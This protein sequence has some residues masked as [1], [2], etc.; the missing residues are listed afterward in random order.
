MML[1]VFFLCALL[2]ACSDVPAVPKLAPQDVIV[3]FGDSLT[4]GTGANEEE[5]YPAVLGKLINRRVI[6]AGVAGETTEQG[7]RRL[8]RVLSEHHPRLLILCLGGNDLLR[9]VDE[10]RTAANLRA[11]I[12]LARER[13]VAVVLMGVPRPGLFTSAPE[14]YSALADEL[15]LPYEGEAIKR[16]LYSNAM[17]SDTIHPNAA[18]YRRIAEDVAELLRASGAI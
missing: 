17:K 12:K 4:H 1:R 15:K 3:A 2:A 5:S 16:V 10:Q 6:R 14:Y 7:L 13:N 8:P 18:G 11:M 9:R